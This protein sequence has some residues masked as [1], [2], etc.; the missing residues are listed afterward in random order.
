MTRSFLLLAI[1]AL[2]SCAKGNNLSDQK[3]V[4]FNLFSSS[5]DPCL[6]PNKCSDRKIIPPTLAL[7][8][9]EESRFKT[10][11]RAGQQVSRSLIKTQATTIEVDG[12]LEEVNCAIGYDQI[13]TI[14]DVKSNEIYIKE[15]KK[16]FK[17]QPDT[18]ACKNLKNMKEYSPLL[19]AIEDRGDITQDDAFSE[20]QDQLK[21]LKMETLTFDNKEI[22]RI[23]GVIEIVQE[24]EDWEGNPFSFTI[25]TSILSM[26]DLNANFFAASIFDHTITR[27]PESLPSE[28]VEEVATV[29]DSIDVSGFNLG[30]FEDRL[31]DDRRETE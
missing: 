19:I 3:R 28:N 11:P 13:R 31:I 22:L 12:D 27:I 7:K 9:F 5:Y 30:D 4:E 24:G 23:S 18:T 20:N 21:K 6:V 8:K 1:L 15:E 25:E 17:F 29:T 14:V 16:N 10:A 2:V 26:I